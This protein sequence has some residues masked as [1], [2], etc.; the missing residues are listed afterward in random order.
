MLTNASAEPEQ[1]LSLGARTAPLPTSTTQPEEHLHPST[2][3]TLTFRHI[4]DPC[5]EV[6][7]RNPKLEQFRKRGLTPPEGPSE[8]CEHRGKCTSPKPMKHKP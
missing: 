5:K 6:P 7:N 4:I 2:V 1:G 8:I 3:A